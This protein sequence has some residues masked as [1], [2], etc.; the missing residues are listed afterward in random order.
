MKAFT[1]ISSAL[2]GPVY[3]KSKLL[4]KIIKSCKIYHNHTN[5]DWNRYSMIIL[6][7]IIM[8]AI[9]KF[10][11]TALTCSISQWFAVL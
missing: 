6:S 7:V 3:K 8:N 5:L 4:Y 11:T 2:V 9:V 1:T 10:D